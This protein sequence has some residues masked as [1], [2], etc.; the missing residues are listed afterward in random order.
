MP[1][2]ES[3]HVCTARVPLDSATTFATRSITERFYSLVRVRSVDGIE[4]IGFCYVGNA[5]GCA[6]RPIVIARF[7]AS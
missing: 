5:G 2:I 6:F 7:G 1:E 4:G 3:V